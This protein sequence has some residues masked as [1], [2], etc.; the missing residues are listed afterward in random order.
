MQP[1]RARVSGPW[2]AALL[3]CAAAM[4]RCAT[5]SDAPVALTDTDRM[6]A[7]FLAGSE[8][9][10]DASVDRLLAGLIGRV[11]AANP[12]V[13]LPEVRCYV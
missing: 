5:A 7:K 10:H 3:A 11:R 2:F 9:M 6:E 8:L 13:G 12:G 4:G 1:I